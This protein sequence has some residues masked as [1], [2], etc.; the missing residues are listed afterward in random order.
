MEDFIAPSLA[1]GWVHVWP[2]Y[3]EVHKANVKFVHAHYKDK[4]A[5]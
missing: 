1:K 5:R 2:P 4:P 3:Q